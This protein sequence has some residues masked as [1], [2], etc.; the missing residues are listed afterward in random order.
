MKN[1]FKKTIAAATLSF[2]LL[3]MGAVPTAQAATTAELQAQINSLL[4]QISVL[5]AQL[6][7]GAV[8]N[9]ACPYTWTRP[10][11]MG[12]T[13]FDVMRLQQFLNNDPSTVVSAFGAGSKGAETQYYGPATAAAVTKFQNKYRAEVLTP[14][15]LVSGTGYFG[16]STMTKTN[17]LCRVVVVP[18][19][20]PAPT[21]TP[22]P[23]P[24]G[25][26]ASLDK[27]K[28]SSGDDTNL[29]EGQQNVQVMNVEFDVEDGDITINRIDV[30]FGYQFGDED[31]PWDTF[32]EVSLYVDDKKVASV[33]T[34]RESEWSD[35]DPYAGAHRVRFS[36]LDIDVDEGDRAKFSVAVTLENSIDGADTGLSWDVF[37]PNNGIRARDEAGIN[38]YAGSNNE[39]VNI[40][41]NEAGSDDELSIK[42]ST[43]DPD[44]TLL[45]LEDNTRSG[46]MT[47][48]A[49]D[50]DTDDSANDI[51]VRELPV[52]LTVSSS[53]VGTFLSDVRL[54]IGND[55]YDDVTI[56]DGVTNNM[57]FEFDNNE[58]VIDAG[59]KETVE[60]EVRFR[61]LALAYE[62]TTIQGSASSTNI[63]AE[64]ADDLKANQLSGS[65]TG[66]VH[67]M[68]T[69]GVN[70]KSP[71]TTIKTQGDNST[72]GIFTVSFD[73]TAFENDFYIAENAGQSATDGVKYTV[74]GPSGFTATT[75]GVLS[76]TA[77]EDSSGVFVVREGETETFTLSVT[78][79]T[80]SSGFHRVAL[81]E[82]F[83]TTNSDGVTD[84][85]T[86]L[87]NP[88]SDYRTGY[89]NINAN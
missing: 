21:P 3:V 66:E 70:A 13:G 54:R 42:T 32:E 27:F 7:G 11:S 75:S 68:R 34:S 44:G 89:L 18:T 5:Q 16:P 4:A 76:S 79:D 41:I 64:G 49:F 19:P 56:T 72:L 55:T 52:S 60:V 45:V 51:E 80:D 47:V 73:L 1:T 61:A 38:Q 57:V 82:I 2:M 87:V 29:E 35:D 77:D 81:N 31:D 46:W 33:N 26:E 14:V 39:T 37:I 10:L 86:N 50:L 17:A 28:T 6:S 48:F 59:D 9:T 85:Q 69:S 58:F 78:V 8:T 12:S 65:A 36:N 43:D 63:D 83:F 24:S 74:Q 15:G 88:A 62:G 53:T 22:T 40:D 71:N 67:T 25:N 30:A 20:T 84:V 23:T